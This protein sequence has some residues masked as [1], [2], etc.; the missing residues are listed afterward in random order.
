MGNPSKRTAL[1]RLDELHRPDII[2]TQETMEEGQKMIGF[3]GKLMEWDFLAIYVVVS[4][5]EVYYYG[6]YEDRKLL[7]SL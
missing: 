6:P 2:L 3:L 5:R 4:S 7:W 1:A